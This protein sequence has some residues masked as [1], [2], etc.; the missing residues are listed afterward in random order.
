M[1]WLTG[2]QKLLTSRNIKSNRKIY[3]MM[4]LLFPK[5]GQLIKIVFPIT[6]NRAF[7]SLIPRDRISAYTYILTFSAVGIS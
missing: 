6:T 3:F 4:N 5:Q 7:N 2:F 1:I